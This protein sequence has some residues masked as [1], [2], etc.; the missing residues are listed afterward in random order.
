[1]SDSRHVV[2]VRRGK[3]LDGAGLTEGATVTRG[4]FLTTLFNC[5]VIGVLLSAVSKPDAPDMTRER[6]RERRERERE[7]E[8]ERGERERESKD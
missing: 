4:Y 3:V 6:E 2:L 7:R 8:R 5:P 1:M